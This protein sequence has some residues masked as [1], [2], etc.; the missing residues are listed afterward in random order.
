MFSLPHTVVCG[1]CLNV[2]RVKISA[3][4]E[5]LPWVPDK[6]KD[7]KPHE[8]VERTVALTW[9]ATSQTALALSKLKT[10]TD[11]VLLAQPSTLQDGASIAPFVIIQQFL[12]REKT[13]AVLSVPIE[14]QLAEAFDLTDGRRTVAHC[15]W[16]DTPPLRA[17]E[18]SP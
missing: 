14:L 11:I 8:F 16:E 15:Q 17:P 13:R 1:H 2:S 5:Y 4:Y 3:A 6:A 10:V 9:A 7:G 18:S 12:D